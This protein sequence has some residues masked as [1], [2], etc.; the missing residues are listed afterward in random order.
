MLNLRN[1]DASELFDLSEVKGRISVSGTS[2]MIAL[3]HHNRKLVLA[4]IMGSTT[5]NNAIRARLMGG[6][7][8][9]KVYGYP[10]NWNTTGLKRDDAG[11]E[12]LVTRDEHFATDMAL[13]VNRNLVEPTSESEYAY[14]MVR[15]GAR[16]LLHDDYAVARAGQIIK[17]FGTNLPIH[18]T[19][20]DW[21]VREVSYQHPSALRSIN[22]WHCQVFAVQLHTDVWTH[23]V[24]DGLRDGK[25]A[26]PERWN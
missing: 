6:K 20:L 8:Q 15:H 17:H 12:Y 25:I 7:K 18:D 10:Q 13:L 22:S 21:L 14:V 5:S 16:N 3:A 4:Y 9:V 24:Q 19:W 26:F 1:F 23:V 2:E 11:Y